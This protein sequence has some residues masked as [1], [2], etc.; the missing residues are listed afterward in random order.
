MPYKTGITGFMGYFYLIIS[1]LI[2]ISIDFLNIYNIIVSYDKIN[3]KEY[4]A[5]S[6]TKIFKFHL[7]TFGQMAWGHIVCFGIGYLVGL[8]CPHVLIGIVCLQLCAV[9]G[10]VCICYQRAEELKEKEVYAA[11]QKSQDRKADAKQFKT[12]VQKSQ[13]RKADFEKE[14][15]ELGRAEAVVAEAEQKNREVVAKYEQ[16]FNDF[17]YWKSPINDNDQNIDALISELCTNPNNDYYYL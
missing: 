14:Q 8:C 16:Q 3:H 15:K 10:D 2:P 7:K 17:Q 5:L 11:F 13:D 1:D 9:Y 12:D 6:G 4:M